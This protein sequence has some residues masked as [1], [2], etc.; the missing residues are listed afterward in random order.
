MW[1]LTAC[2][3]LGLHAAA[4]RCVDHYAV[5]GASP[6][7]SIRVLR[8][9]RNALA[10]EWHPDKNCGSKDA[11]A[12]FREVQEAFEVLGDKSRRATYD[13]GYRA[14]RCPR[15]ERTCRDCCGNADQKFPGGGAGGRRKEKDSGKQRKS[16]GGRSR[17]DSRQS[18]EKPGRGPSEPRDDG[19]RRFKLRFTLIVGVLCLVIACRPNG[20]PDVIDLTDDKAA[21]D[22]TADSDDEDD[23]GVIDLTDD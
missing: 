22:L 19:G 17:S 11:E 12:Y 15:V 21:I 3:V 23:A 6:V 5:L 1:S 16:D 4:G 18:R 10:L 20:I 2:W 7:S 9:R 13:F 14:S 8:K